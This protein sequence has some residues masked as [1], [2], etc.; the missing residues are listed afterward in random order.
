MFYNKTIILLEEIIMKKIK[1]LR[2]GG[3]KTLEKM[4]NEFIIN[5]KYGA[6]L[7][8]IED[9]EEYVGDVFSIDII[10]A[11]GGFLANILYESRIYFTPNFL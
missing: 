6:D 9:G 5:E 2:H 3:I 8:N 10:Y 7:E 4:V 11:D 1:L